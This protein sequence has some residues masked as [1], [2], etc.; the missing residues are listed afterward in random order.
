MNE[1]KI[2]KAPNVP[3]FVRFVASTIPMVFDD[4]MSYY[5]ALANLVHYIQD[6]VDVVNNNATVTEEYIQ[7]TKD[8]KEYMDHYFDNLNV[9]NEI[10]NKL[11][12]MAEDGTLTAILNEYFASY[13]DPQIQSQNRR[14]SSVEDLVNSAVSGAPVAV[15]SRSNMTD[16]NKIYVLTSDG[17]WYYYNS[18]NST[19]TAGG[20]YQSTALGSGSVHLGSLDN[21]LAG[22]ITQPNT[23]ITKLR[24]LQFGNNANHPNFLSPFLLK[25]GTVISVSS[26]F[27]TNYHWRL[28]RVPTDAPISVVTTGGI[29]NNYTT[30]TTYTLLNDEYCIFQ[31]NPIDDNWNTTDYTVDRTYKPDN[32]DINVLYF[33][34]KSDKFKLIDVDNTKVFNSLFCSTYYNTGN[35]FYTANRMTTCRIYSNYP[36]LVHIKDGMQYAINTYADGV[37]GSPR[38]SDTGWI[39][40]DRIIQPNT[41]FVVGF[42]TPTND[43]FINDTDYGSYLELNSYANFKYVDK[44]VDDHISSVGLSYNYQGV[45]LDL[46]YNHGYSYEASTPIPQGMRDIQAFTIYGNYIFQFYSTGTGLLRIFDKSTG[47]LIAEH[48]GLSSQHGGAC[49]FSKTFVDENDDFPLLYV[50][51][52]Y[53]NPD[54]GQIHVY[55][56][57]DVNTVSFYKAYHFDP[58]VVGYGA[59]QCYDFDTGLCYSFGYTKSDFADRTDNPVKVNVIDLTKETLIIDNVYTLDIVDNYKIPYVYVMQSAKFLNGLCYIPSS[60]QSNVQASDIRV[61]DPN[62]KTFVANFPNLP[63]PLRGEIEDL[64]FVKNATTSKYDMIVGV[65]GDQNYWKLSFM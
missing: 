64:D 57:Q 16:H 36:V 20:T 26:E 2:E 14:I 59:V 51:T 55:R 8:M 31:W 17:K 43:N 37:D 21:Q 10:N 38:Q 44:Y 13:V 53:G 50:S 3:A 61:F 34:P 12:A 42:R 28:V 33:W 1:D 19:W 56:V 23:D 41:W 65:S 11:D 54:G 4:S 47:S 46:Q 9:Q 24:L 39:T 60:Y 45:N 18:T 49:M 52:G 22:Y 5:E 40:E 63:V 35:A 58:S 27:V 48:S 15:S 30:D 7:I 25:A 62:R 29:I 32:D 6:T